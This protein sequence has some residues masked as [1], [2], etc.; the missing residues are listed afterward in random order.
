MRIVCVL[1]NQL[2]CFLSFYNDAF[3]IKK[4]PDNPQKNSLKELGEITANEKLK[5]NSLKFN[6][7]SM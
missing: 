1:E 6:F 5:R 3:S 4:T 7:L 2:L